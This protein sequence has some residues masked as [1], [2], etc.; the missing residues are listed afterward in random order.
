MTSSKRPG[1]VLA[2]TAVATVALAGCAGEDS[3]TGS[4]AAAGLTKSEIVLGNVGTYSGPQGATSKNMPAFYKAWAEWRN[5]NGGIAGHPVRIVT[6][7]DK[8]DAATA[9]SA[10]KRL[11]ENEQVLAMV[12]VAESGL[13]TTWA[14][15]VS[16]KNVPV[17]G[18]YAY[19]PVWNSNPAFFP[20]TSTLVTAVASGGNIAKL[21]GKQVYGVV[22]C[23]EQSACAEA[24]KFHESTSKAE[25][26]TF[27][28]GGTVPVTAP[29]YTATCLAAKNAGVDALS[30][31][32]GDSAI[33]RLATDCARQGYRPTYIF[34]AT[35]VTP[36][37]LENRE[38]E[39]AIVP[40][41]SFPWFY[42]GQETAEFR[43]VLA[44]LD[45][46]EKDVN[47]ALSLAFTAVKLFEKAAANV[48]DTPT[49]DEIRKGLYAIKDETL[50]GLTPPLTFTEGA[51]D[52]SVNC[53]FVST[54]KDGAM[55]AP[56][57]LKVDCLDEK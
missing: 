10:V 40:L 19:T 52:R 48:S 38:L 7:D 43:E 11:V 28:Y 45:L 25:G 12:G 46:K 53:F 17:V 32:L 1:M 18:G 57:G 24:I 37:V 5:A 31:G 4:P 27:G 39:G 16:Q 44:K 20:S 34:N 56:Q 9:T 33:S 35:S 26:L 50:G 14:D 47:P 30:V 3:A 6:I 23:S 15:Y 51:A 49:S 55:V 36:Q 42:E 54:I 8:S 21:Q 29:N 13:E 2:I 41:T 22:N